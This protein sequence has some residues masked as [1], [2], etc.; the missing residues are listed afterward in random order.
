MQRTLTTLLGAAA[1]ALTL[2]T[3][4]AADLR[5]GGEIVETLADGRTAV[6]GS[7]VEYAP[8]GRVSFTWHVGRQPEEATRIQVEIRPDPLGAALTLYHGDWANL[9]DEAS[10]LRANYESGWDGVLARFKARAEA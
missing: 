5:I 9:G 10:H 2:T 6:W 4:N 8:P 3:A 7:F 1:L